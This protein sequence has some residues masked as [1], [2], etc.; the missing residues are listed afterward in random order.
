VDRDRPPLS[1][2]SNTELDL[3]IRALV[4][5]IASLK[6]QI[7]SPSARRKRTRRLL[8]GTALMVGGFVG[9]TV[10]PLTVVLVAVG[11][12][13]W[14]DSVDEDAKTYNR[15]RRIQQEIP[16]LEREFSEAEEEIRRRRP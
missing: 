8:R 3:L 16:F 12:W 6:T 9:A 4:A 5:K 11:L 2:L 10:N 7:E 13:D 14:F 15:E 1:T